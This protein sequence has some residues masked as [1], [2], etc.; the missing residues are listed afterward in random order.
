[1]PDGYLQTQ[2][3][4]RGVRE[5]A[6]FGGWTYVPQFWFGPWAWLV[7]VLGFALVIAVL[8]VPAAWRLGNELHTWAAAYVVYIAAVVEP[9]SSLARFLL[10][11]FPLGAVTAGVV[12]RPP[13]ARRWWLGAV[14]VLMLGAAGALGPA[15]V[16]G[17]PGGRLAAVIGLRAAP[18]GLDV[19]PIGG[20]TGIRTGEGAGVN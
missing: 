19:R 3:A 8:V 15:D 16:A 20:L 13:A 10:L 12:T 18:V 2:E 7:V 11:A 4:W 5:V 9:G 6:P 1:M 17:E 14:V